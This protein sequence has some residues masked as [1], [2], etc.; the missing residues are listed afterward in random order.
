[1]N[2]ANDIGGLSGRGHLAGFDQKPSAINLV[3]IFEQSAFG[4]AGSA[5]TI[6]II[7]ATMAR[8]HEQARLRKPAHRTP[9][10]RAVDGED[11]KILP[12]HVANP[13]GD[14]RRVSV[15]WIHNGISIRGQAS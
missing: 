15:P 14:I 4:G 11:L 5:R 6:L 2:L 10:M 8:A 1:M 9:Q 12:V 3:V 13:A 7:N